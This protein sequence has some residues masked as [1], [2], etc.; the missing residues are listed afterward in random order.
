MSNPPNLTSNAYGSQRTRKGKQY[1]DGS[2]GKAIDDL[3]RDID[4]AFNT[5]E[6]NNDMGMCSSAYIA[7][8]ANPTDGQLVTI[9]A[10][11]YEF[12]NDNSV[13]GG[14]IAVTIG[15]S[16]ADTRANLIAAVNGTAS[17]S[18]LHATAIDSVSGVAAAAVG[19]LDLKAAEVDGDG[20]GGATDV[21][22][23]TADRPGGTPVGAA[24]SAA[25]SKTVAGAWNKSNINE[26]IGLAP[27]T[28]MS[29]F[30]AALADDS[31]TTYRLDF[32]FTINSFSVTL[33]DDGGQLLDMGANDTVTIVG[34][35]ALLITIGAATT[36]PASGATV[37]GVVW[38]T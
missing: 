19:T 12:D 15:A 18:G 36:I 29:A 10:D 21:I 23:I 38:G 6:D 25:L 24:L 16:A 1:R 14:K 11:S 33:R 26:Q 2:L 9:G 20:A 22:F 30:A 4:A 13:G 28:K 31:A 7:M 8:S 32:P 34:G 35:S 37:A 27:S 3:N 17:F 5:M